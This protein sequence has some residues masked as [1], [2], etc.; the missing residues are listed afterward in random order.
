MLLRFTTAAAPFFGGVVA[1]DG[2]SNARARG[3]TTGAVL[4]PRG[5]KGGCP[6]VGGRSP[7]GRRPPA[8]ERLSSF[9]LSH[10]DLENYVHFFII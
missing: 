6:D 7:Q 3:G 8:A 4:V 5:K 2:D 1:R 9:Y 10:V